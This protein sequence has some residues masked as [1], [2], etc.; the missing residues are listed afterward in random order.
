MKFID[1]VFL[2]AI[3]IFTSCGNQTNEQAETTTAINPDSLSDFP[4]F[5]IRLC[6][7]R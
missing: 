6:W 7:V 5:Q 1:L 4:L 3:A 2:F